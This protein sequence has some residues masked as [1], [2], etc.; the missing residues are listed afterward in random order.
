MKNVLPELSGKDYIEALH[1]DYDIRFCREDEFDDLVGF[2]RDHWRSDH[3]FVLSKTVLDYH[4]YDK[5][6]KRY[7]F[8]IA[9]ERRTN[10]IHSILGFVPI[11][12]YDEG[13]DKMFVWPCIWK[14]RDDV[15]RKGLGV[16]L[17]HHLATTLDIDVLSI[18]GISEI[19][20][21]I[22]KHLNFKTGKMKHYVMPN[23]E[24]K[25]KL[26]LGLDSIGYKFEAG[27]DTMKLVELDRES[28]DK[29]PAD[30]PIFT[31]NSRYK[32]KNYFIGRFFEHP[33]YKYRFL[34]I[35]DGSGPVAIMVVRACGY[36]GANCLRIVDFIGDV[37][38]LPNAKN[39]IQDYIRKNDYEYVDFIELGLEDEPIKNAGFINRPDY[40][41]IIVPNYFEP[42]LQENGDLDYAYKTSVDVGTFT[43]FKADAD[44]DRPNLLQ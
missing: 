38:N 16:S 10:E 43:C 17:Y 36:E 2:L 1:E 41:D 34:A 6:N 24:K 40:P 14:S 22:Y 27:T 31:V 37:R 18:I 25:S 13:N 39:Q 21:S 33:V 12:Q 11:G 44:Q 23:T 15:N 5:K 3:I 29:I 9:R 8:V 35:C 28:Y 42:F 32:S 19:A 7:N 26:A 20:L 4:H 30:S